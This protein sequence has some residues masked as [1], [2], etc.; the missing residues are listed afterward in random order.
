VVGV[1]ALVSPKMPYHVGQ[2]SL[3]KRPMRR[4]SIETME[5]GSSF[6]SFTQAAVACRPRS[7]FTWSSR[8]RAMKIISLSTVLPS[9]SRKRM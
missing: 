1:G 5:N 9:G 3:G 7:F 6:A 4:S 2:T 8:S